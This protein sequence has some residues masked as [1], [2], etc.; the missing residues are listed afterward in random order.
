[1]RIARFPEAEVPRDLRLQM[2]ALQRQAW[3]DDGPLEARPVHDPALRPESLLL[4]DG[5]RV[6]AALDI[7]SKRISHRC[8][9]Y[10][11]RGLS[12]V[13][14]DESLRRR[15]HGRRLVEFARRA[16]ADGGADLGIFT[17]DR[18]LQP[19]YEAAGWQALP[20]TVLVGGT[21]SAPFPSDRFDKVTLG[22]FFTAKAKRAESE[23]VGAR[24]ELHPGEIDRLW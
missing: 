12:A 15:G 24:I 10:D 21:A 17:C 14:T 11:A 5:A 6:V 9:S 1:M 22:C 20:G 23:F 13:V 4:V 18:P 2:L 16:I 19:F 3:P 7:L 8:S